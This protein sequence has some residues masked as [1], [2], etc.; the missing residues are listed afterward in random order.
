MYDRVNILCHQNACTEALA[1]LAAVGNRHNKYDCKLC[2]NAVPVTE[3]ALEASKSH[4][5]AAKTL[6][7]VETADVSYFE[8]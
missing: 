4:I 6:T 8:S 3:G 2:D 7:D 1:I 5:W